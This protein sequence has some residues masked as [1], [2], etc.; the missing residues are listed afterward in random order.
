MKAL[1]L[2][3]NSF[4]I[5]G[6]EIPQI[7]NENEVLIKLKFAALNHRDEW[8]RVGQY[9]KIQYPSILGSDG[10]GV[11]EQVGTAVD[12]SWI[13]KEVIINPNINWGNNPKAQ[14]RAYQI[15]GM[16]T[17]GTIAE[18][19]VV[20]I[21]RIKTKPNYLTLEQAAAF[22]LGG[23]TAFNACFNKGMINQNSKVLISG[24]GG[25]VAQ[26]AFLFSMAVGAEV[27]VTSSKN[28][29]VDK[30][31][32][33]GATGGCN[34][35][36]EEDMKLM[37]KAA[38][39]FDVIIDSACG[40]GMNLLL[41]LLKQNGRYVFYGATRGLPKDLNM[42]N[43]FWN[44]LQLLGSTM[45]SDEDFNNMVDFIETHKIIPIIDET[46]N[47]DDA[48]VAFDRMAAGKQFG[49]IIIKI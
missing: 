20:N 11:I 47:L 8:I 28:E 45:G 13:G 4:G 12:N 42:R 43:I 34:Y 40:D 37:S 48:V 30:C 6:V 16:P 18:Y 41:S 38:N 7:K 36:I 39:G 29:V 1:V 5:Q 46:Y 35:K 17:Q 23:L 44:H 15:L 19:I 49:K 26:F 3:E 27:F 21:D 31:M 9:A 2:N 24:V 33:L 32:Q 22:P 25:G 10:S 14:N